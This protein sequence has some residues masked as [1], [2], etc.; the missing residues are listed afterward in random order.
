M[1]L[2]AENQLVGTYPGYAVFR[3]LYED[4]SGRR[5]SVGTSRE[6]NMMEQRT[7]SSGKLAKYPQQ[8]IIFEKFRLKES[9]LIQVPKTYD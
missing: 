5:F 9:D 6:F 1:K 4:E 2:I 3:N 7:L 8:S